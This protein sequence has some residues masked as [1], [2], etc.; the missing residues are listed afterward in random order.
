MKFG[1]FEVYI[2]ICVEN[3]ISVSNDPNSTLDKA[4]ID[5]NFSPKIPCRTM[6]RCMIKC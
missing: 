2:K 6:N 3:L 5:L 1:I 4:G